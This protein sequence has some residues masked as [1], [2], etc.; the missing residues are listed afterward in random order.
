MS[1]LTELNTFSDGTITF[2]DNRTPRPV[3]EEFLYAPDADQEIRSATFSPINNVTL[4]DIIR[5]AD[6]D[7]RFFIDVGTSGFTVNWGTL[8]SGITSSL[9]APGYYE[10]QGITSVSDFNSIT[11]SI[12][13]NENYGD[14]TYTVGFTWSGGNTF[15]WTVSATVF[16]A[17][18]DAETTIECI[19]T[20]IIEISATMPARFSFSVN[21][22]DIPLVMSI[23]LAASVEKYSV[24]IS[25]ATAG[26]TYSTN[27]D[28]LLEDTPLIVYPATYDGIRM[29]LSTPTQPTSRN[30]YNITRKGN[31]QV[32]TAESK[33]G[34]ASLLLDG[35]GDGLQIGDTDFADFRFN[36]AYTIECFVNFTGSSI[37]RIINNNSTYLGIANLTWWYNGSTGKL[38]FQ[39]SVS[40]QNVLLESTNTFTTG[41]WYHIAIVKDTDTWYM[42][43]DGTLEASGGLTGNSPAK[44][45]NNDGFYIGLDAETAPTLQGNGLYGY[46]DEVRI[47][48][49]ARYTTG[50]TV[51]TSAFTNDA[52][53]RLLIHMDGSN[54]STTFSDDNTDYATPEI[55]SV[56]HSAVSFVRNEVSFDLGGAVIRG[57]PGILFGNYVEYGSGDQSLIPL[58]DL[59]FVNLRE[60][61][62][63]FHAKRTDSSGPQT[64]FASWNTTD[65]SQ[66]CFRIGFNEAG[67]RDNFIFDYYDDNGVLQSFTSTAS[68][69][70]G[71]TTW[72]H[73]AIVKDVNNIKFYA[74]GT[75]IGSIASSIFR[76]PIFD[77]SLGSTD[78]NA[79][80]F[81]GGLDDFRI[82]RTARY[83]ENFTTPA[84]EFT[85]D[86]ETLCLFHFNETEGSSTT[87]DD[88]TGTVTYQPVS[89]DRPTQTITIE[90]T[91]SEV[92]TALNGNITVTPGTGYTSDFDITYQAF[93][94]TEAQ[95]NVETQTVTR[96]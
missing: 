4:V 79:N 24:L 88:Y 20:P 57:A 56:S 34:S 41:T 26:L 1:S 63:E 64:V 2:T 3:F 23:T 62:V 80:H 86:G 68:Y 36:S 25:E 14:N 89:F 47:S 19:P 51:P 28:Y 73:F 81:I 78:N 12:A 90:G 7:L 71:S 58:E 30:A 77:Y 72:I 95:S 93:T 17:I 29:E 44:D 76:Q 22:V 48:D 49:T 69:G 94:S 50:F 60:W 92:N 91:T 96:T 5:P 13:I 39:E 75:Q 74:N 8:P 61:T 16:Y 33:F 37:E 43:V 83:T 15:S 55:D 42:Y 6:A 85:N 54:G 70:V 10:L 82:S 84:S 11:P 66:S 65:S 46:I 52:N 27:T 32:S 31:A 67:T 18:I 59:D 87:T 45:E 35:I 40:T 38:W 53:T 21:L 9:T